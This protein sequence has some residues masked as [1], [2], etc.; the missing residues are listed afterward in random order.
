M[1]ATF[2]GLVHDA[3]VGSFISLYRAFNSRGGKNNTT[4]SGA[5]K[6][7]IRFGFLSYGGISRLHKKSSL[8]W[9]CFLHRI[10]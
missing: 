1:S 6:N 2:P 9:K 7:K 8:K 3:E 4:D 5:R 10:G